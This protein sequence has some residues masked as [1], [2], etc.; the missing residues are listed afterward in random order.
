MN[1]ILGLITSLVLVC[2]AAYTQDKV[3]S[4]KQLLLLDRSDTTKIKLELCKLQKKIDSIEVYCL[5]LIPLEDSLEYGTLYADVFRKL[6]KLHYRKGNISIAA[7]YNMRAFQ[8]YRLQ[9]EDSL[10]ALT[11][12]N[13]GVFYKNTGQYE[14]A[15]IIFNKSVEYALRGKDTL[16][17]AHIYNGMG[18][19]KERQ[20]Q[21]DSAIIYYNKSLDIYEQFGENDSGKSNTINNIGSIRLSQERF[22]DALISFKKA[23]QVAR[24]RKDTSSMIT[25]F[26]NI[27]G[28]YIKKED[29][30]NARNYLMQADTISFTPSIKTIG[31]TV[32]HLGILYKNLEEYD[33][34]LSYLNQA[35][36]IAEYTRHPIYLYQSYTNR[37]NVYRHEGKYHRSLKD[38]RIGLGYAK[39]TPEISLHY[40][41]YEAV[42]LGFKNVQEYD[43]AYYYLRKAYELRDT[44]LQG[45]RIK[46]VS[47]IETKYAVR[48]KNDSLLIQQAQI[49]LQNSELSKTRLRS[50]LVL[51]IAGLI[52]TLLGAGIL[53]YR[54][55]W[56]MEAAERAAVENG[57]KQL[58]IE[59]KKIIE[60]LQRTKDFIN[61]K[62]VLDKHITISSQRVRIGDIYRV[63]SHNKQV[64]IYTTSGEIKHYCSMTEMSKTLPEAYFVRVNR[65][66][67]IN[68][69]SI[70]SADSRR[71]FLKN[72]E[73][74][75]LGRPFYYNFREQ[76]QQYKDVT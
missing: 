72:G 34:A 47:D 74:F 55:N 42:A 37:G 20:N 27:G 45:E 39:N 32:L 76:Y 58:L 64:I 75:K 51:G 3:D 14:D 25:A 28:T 68:L 11:G 12:S 70:K 7:A 44:T 8:N 38:Y 16:R 69:A 61:S 26:N 50:W 33:T 35:V 21:L 63:Q 10:A 9:E 67:I 2:F 46:A 48:Q 73:D 40:L 22:D 1:R 15:L 71:V 19:V 59:N 56:R 24:E 60:E 66:H 31:Y 65:Y 4:L 6:M 41:L 13:A 18:T 23:L 17:L 62:D 36:E 5:D 43:S 49:E 30:N 29:W 53:T 57:N 52:I 54:N